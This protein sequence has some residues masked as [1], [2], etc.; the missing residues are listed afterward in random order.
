[1]AEGT[2]Q[3]A[4]TVE[5]LLK[6][7]ND[8]DRKYICG[9][10]TDSCFM[11]HED[12]PCFFY[13]SKAESRR[14]PFNQGMIKYLHK[15]CPS[16][17]AG[18]ECD[19]GK[20]CDMC[21]SYLELSYHPCVYKTKICPK[22]PHPLQDYCPDAHQ[23]SEIRDV[24]GYLELLG[25]EKVQEITNA[26]FTRDDPNEEDKQTEDV[27]TPL[28][29][30]Q[31]SRKKSMKKSVSMNV[32]TEGGIESAL[33]QP[34]QQQPQQNNK[35]NR[36]KKNKSKGRNG[37]KAAGSGTIFFLD[38]NVFKVKQC[39][40]GSNHNP[41][42]CMHYHDFKRDRRRPLGNYSSESCLSMSKTGD[43]IH[44]DECK[45]SHNRVEEFYHP[46]KYKV[47]FCSTYPDNTATCEYGEY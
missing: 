40:A 33:S 30:S 41:K 25:P 2:Q 14:R 37:Y 13:H 6:L 35:R 17:S 7:E 21:H 31:P 10:K 32:T 45:R 18:D 46:E 29:E 12:Q 24:S 23:E 26:N 5:A 38:L 9:Y 43:C 15:M 4:K 39:K 34:Q 20:D 19:V 1:M 27:I 28:P 11:K 3:P 16:V 47:K 22:G 42:K 36:K 8:N 44:G